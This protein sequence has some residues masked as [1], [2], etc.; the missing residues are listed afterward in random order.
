MNCSKQLLFYN[1]KKQTASVK[2][3]P[4]GPWEGFPLFCFVFVFVFIFN[5]QMLTL[6][7]H[8]LYQTAFEIFFDMRVESPNKSGL[9][10]SLNTR[11]IWNKFVDMAWG[12]TTFS[13]VYSLTP[14]PTASSALVTLLFSL[15]GNHQCCFFD[16]TLISISLKPTAE[17]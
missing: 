6:T 17:L 1:N 4:K 12:E 7:M 5:V 9:T 16:E 15:W 13:W 3:N 11:W 8:Y 2:V 10:A 14:F